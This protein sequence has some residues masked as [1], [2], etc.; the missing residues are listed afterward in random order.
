M[1]RAG[2]RICRAEAPWGKRTRPRGFTT[3]DTRNTTGTRSLHV[4]TVSDTLTPSD[5]VSVAPTPGDTLTVTRDVT[6]DAVRRSASADS[7]AR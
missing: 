3:G 1:P 2:P 6:Q 4:P 5:V 7:L